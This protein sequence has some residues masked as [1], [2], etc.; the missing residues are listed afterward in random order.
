MSTSEDV[1]RK[2]LK[3]ID[4]YPLTYA[5]VLNWEKIEKFQSRPD[6]I[7]IT[8]YPKSGTTWLSEIVDM[9]LNDG[10]VQKCKSEMLLPLKFQCWN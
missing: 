6:D 10:N 8:T 5:F 2:D 1:C 3:V 4:G 7:V 9:V